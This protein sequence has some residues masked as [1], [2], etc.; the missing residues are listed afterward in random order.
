MNL[1]EQLTNPTCFEQNRLPACS[2]HIFWHGTEQVPRMLCLDGTWAVQVVSD[3]S[4]RTPDFETRHQNTWQT[5]QIPGHLN[6]E[7]FEPLQ[8][9]NTAYPWD[10]LQQLTPPELPAQI[11]TAQL[12]RTFVVPDDWMGQPLRLWL[13]GVEPACRIWIN[14]TYI[15]YTESSFDAAQFDV[16]NA[17]HTGENIIAIEVYR[18]A[19]GVWLED[20][21]FWRF[22]GIFRSVRLYPIPAAHVNDLRVTANMDGHLTISAALQGQAEQAT[23]SLFAPDGT[24]VVEQTVSIRKSTPL[25]WQH[26]VRYPK[27]WSAEQPN[28]YQ[29]RITLMQNGQIIETV[30]QAVGFRT[31]RIEHNV[32]RLNGQRLVLHGVNRHEFCAQSGRVVSVEQMEWDAREMKRNNINAVRTSHYPNRKEWYDICDRIGLYVI[33]ETNLETHGSWNVLG[34]EPW[35]KRIPDS[36]PQWMEAVCARGQAMVARE[37]NHPSILFWSC[38]NESNAGQVIF[39]LSKRIHKWDDTRLVHYEGISQDPRYPFGHTPYEKTSDVR[40]TMYWPPEKAEWV[41]QNFTDK[42]YIQC[43]YAHAMGNSTGSIEDYIALEEKYSHY[44]GGFIWDWVD[45]LIE[46]DDKLY[47]GGDFQE[48]VHSGDFC[49]NG[50]VF[51]DRT[52]TPKLAAVKAAYSNYVLTLSPKKLT[53]RNKSLFTNI[54][55]YEIVICCMADGIEFNRQQLHTSCAPGQCVTVSWSLPE[56]C[57]NGEITVSASLHTTTDTEWAQKGFAICSTQMI[58]Y[59]RAARQTGWHMI[60]GTEHI[61]FQGNQLTILFDKH[62]GKL[63][64]IQ[65]K[66]G[67][68]WV[69]K[70]LAPTFWRAPVSNDIASNWPAEKAMWKTATLY[71]VFEH[72][73]CEEQ[74]TAYQITSVYRLPLTPAIKCTVRYRLEADD[75]I[76]VQVNCDKP[77]SLPA[78]FCF[79]IEMTTFAQNDT[80]EYY[81]YGPQETAS[82][83]LLGAQLG[84]WHC[85]VSSELTPYM[86]PQDCAVH[87]GVRWATCGGLRFQPVQ[88]MELSALPW[89]CH[90]IEQAAHRWELPPADKTVLRLLAWSCGVGGDDTWGARPREAYQMQQAPLWME[91]EIM[92]EA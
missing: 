43:E 61:G 29:L 85:H 9:T 50:L 72:M 3:L 63:I 70:P 21:D 11:P 62:N 14:G 20:Q 77:E 82:D 91:L 19:S 67:C 25:T 28:L 86:T 26:T 7:G 15:G 52:P 1:R 35:M 55:E 65:D 46:R 22:W 34:Q 87:C 57:P 68:E 76:R 40:S 79:G 30:E 49:A 75:H 33:D 84:R 47:Y 27:L 36:N 10:G 71:P 69:K 54:S 42:P 18:W 44:Q 48:R 17:I 81:G 66:S 80:V 13:G 78:P 45:Q 4:A 58:L 8:Y 90:E 59:S 24:L 51:A 2:D 5:M 92:P 60:R 88:P 12:T 32:I 74:G 56:S 6:F 41:L 23:F 31:I 16:T 39:E 83:R 53:I 89:D 37:K 64:S 38:G 73:Q